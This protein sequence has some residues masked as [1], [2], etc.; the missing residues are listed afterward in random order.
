[1]TNLHTLDAISTFFKRNQVPIVYISTSPFNLIGADS[2]IGGFEFINSVDSFEHR[3]PRIFLTSDVATHPLS[4]FVQANRYLLNHPEV[5]AHLRAR[6]RGYALF[7]MFDEEAAAAVERL[8]WR[9]AFPPTRLRHHLDSKVTTTEL[10]NRAGVSSVPNML[11]P[12]QSYADLRRVAGHL[13]PDL[14][15]QLPY[16]DSGG[17]TF[18]ISSEQEFA[19]H[20]EAIAAEPAVKVMRRI[21]CRQG[22]IEGCATRHGTLVGPL[23]T[24]LIGL[25][26]LTPLPGG[27]CGNELLATGSGPFS[28]EVRRQAMAAVQTIGAELRQAGYWGCFGLDFLLDMDTDELYLGELNPRITGATPLTSQ[29]A[30]DRELPPL[31]LFHLLEALGVDYEVDVADYNRRWLVPDDLG[32]WCQL[33]VEQ[34]GPESVDVLSAPRAGIWRLNNDGTASYARAAFEPRTITGEQE[35]LVLSTATA[36]H[37]A[38]MSHSLFRML[39]RGRAMGDDWTLNDRAIAWV[40]ALRAHNSLRRHD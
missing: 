14:V 21:R 34:L 31:L 22:T 24:E 36:G 10:A 1:M 23:Q 11:A 30:L 19:P 3:H 15:V 16:G 8:G 27:W 6:G 37:T 18:F 13:G 2:W 35:A 28:G 4:T 25:P 7:L 29:A 17:T 40:G 20:A 39:L 9:V 26:A 38:P 32:G 33:I 12:V 5:Q